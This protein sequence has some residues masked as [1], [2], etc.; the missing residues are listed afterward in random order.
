MR[1]AECGVRSAECG[2]RSA[3]CGVLNAECGMRNAEWVGGIA[4]EV[5]YFWCRRACALF[6][7]PLQEHLFYYNVNYLKYQQ[8]SDFKNEKIKKKV[9]DSFEN[10]FIGTFKKFQPKGAD[11]C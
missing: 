3:E 7:Y 4:R 11:F 10:P 2:V 6:F 8:K 1:S 9:F 5:C